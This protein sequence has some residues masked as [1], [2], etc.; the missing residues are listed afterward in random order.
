MAGV[1]LLTLGAALA[2]VAAVRTRDVLLR[3]RL[4][5]VQQERGL[6]DVCRYSLV[7]LP[8][9]DGSVACPEC[10]SITEVD[11]SL[12]ERSRDDSRRGIFVRR[13]A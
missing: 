13:P 12:S 7:G 1:M 6:C 8:V 10:G 4:R 5:I 2:P 9:V 3:R 11:E